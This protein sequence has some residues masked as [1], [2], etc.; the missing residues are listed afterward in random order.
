MGKTAN[1]SKH[2]MCESGSG[3][4]WHAFKSTLTLKLKFVMAKIQNELPN[5]S[6]KIPS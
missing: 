1:E 4:E 6:L 2:K 5:E 3:V